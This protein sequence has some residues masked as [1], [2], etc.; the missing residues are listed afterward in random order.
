MP[1]G[2]ET[3]LLA[4]DEA[5]VRA[6]LADGLRGLGYTVLEAANGDE[7]LG[8]VCGY[9]GVVDLLL[10]DVV[11]PHTG[12][13]VLA[14]WLRARYPA[15]GVL[16]I[17]GYL[18][19]DAAQAMEHSLGAAFLRKPFTLATLARKVRNVLDRCSGAA[20]EER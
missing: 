9:E 14:E 6:M 8:V 17:S 11:M 4:E 1:S 10:A 5:A 16:L 18:D 7:A 13:G 12:G 20:A 3:V 2:T 19:C 15:L